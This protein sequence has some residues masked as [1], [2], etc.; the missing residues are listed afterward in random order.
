[1]KIGLVGAGLQGR[2]RAQAIRSAG[3]AGLLIYDIDTQKAKRLAEEFKGE[4]V[5]NWQELMIDKDV[6]VVVVCT[7]P[8][9]HAEISIMAMNNGKHVLCEKPLAQKLLQAKQ[10]LRAAKKNKV[11]LKCG[12]N[13]RFHPGIRLVKEWIDNGEIGDLIFLR[14]RYGIGGRPDYDKDW[15]ANAMIS[16]GGQV[17]DQGIHII[18]LSRWFLGDFIEVA[19]LT[20]T[21]YWDISPLEDNAYAILSGKRGNTAFLHASWTQWI[22]L[23]SLEIFGRDGYAIVEGLGG[24]YGNEKATLGKRIFTK[25]FEE[26]VVYFRGA[27][28]SWDEEWKEFISSIKE[29]REP[30][31]NGHDG[32]EALIIADAIYK[33]AKSK[34]FI[35]IK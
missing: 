21:G 18:D 26:K 34:R 8:D 14:C 35:Q 24:S 23:F 33:S 3:P 29:K 17:L 28:V 15:R 7:P 4:V 1:M 9:S 31:A 19:A 5:S 6:D 20:Q 25:P 22:N 30:V 32:V 10:M 12:F 27:D 13:L 2:R 16:G 11:N